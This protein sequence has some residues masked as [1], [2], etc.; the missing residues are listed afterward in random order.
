VPKAAFEK[1]SKDNDTCGAEVPVTRLALG[2]DN[3][4]GHA[5]VYLEQVTATM[6]VQVQAAVTVAQ[7]GCIYAPHA[8]TVPAGTRL[9]I[10]NDDP[11]LHNVHARQVV[12][13]QRTTIFNIAQPLKGQRTIVEPGLGT[14][15]IVELT[16]EAGHP[17]MTGYVLVADHPYTAVTD[18]NGA[19][20]IANVPPGTYRIRMWHEGVRLTNVYASLQ[21][22]EYESPYEA[23]EQ[24]VVPATGD[25]EVTF[26]FAL[27]QS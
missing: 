7:K 6:P 16:C 5:F 13:E 8:M 4:V 21:R 27:R 10:V 26:S 17:W 11:I 9:T 22:Y 3:G 25:V 2:A 14:P 24:V 12:A 15:G 23:T 19:F 20:S 18:E 1:V